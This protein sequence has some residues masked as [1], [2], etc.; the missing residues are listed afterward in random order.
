MKEIGLK[1]QNK[2]VFKESGFKIMNLRGSCNKLDS[3]ICN[4]ILQKKKRKFD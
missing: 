3:K 2:Y 1:Q 4:C